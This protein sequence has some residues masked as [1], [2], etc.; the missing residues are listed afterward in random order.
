MTGGDVASHA[1]T[2]LGHVSQASIR[3]SRRGL[4]GGVRDGCSGGG[5][6]GGGGATDRAR[7]SS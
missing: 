7:A 4:V 6:G 1:G 2:T 5:P 3:A